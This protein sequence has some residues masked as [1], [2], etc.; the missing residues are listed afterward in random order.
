MKS[1]QSLRV[2]ATVTHRA[3][4][5]IFGVVQAIHHG[6]AL[7]RWTAQTRTLAKIQSLRVVHKRQWRGKIKR[8]MG[9]AC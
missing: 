9:L 5:S 7:A 1:I 4:P 3:S 2:G 8:K 6:A